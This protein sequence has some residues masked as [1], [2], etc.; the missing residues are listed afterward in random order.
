[1]AR[2]KKR[3][4]GRYQRKVTLS[5][6]KQKFV[7]GKTIAE[8]NAAANALMSQDTAGLE[9]GDHTLVGE[10]TTLEP[11]YRPSRRWRRYD[12]LRIHPVVELSRCGPCAVLPASP[13]AAAHLRNDTLSCRGRL[14]NS[15]KTNGTQQH[16]GHRRYLYSSGT[17]RFAPC[18]R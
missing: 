3:K 15:T 2:L 8:V 5:N 12:P 4:D 10:Y 1:M 14:T 6:G 7:Y 9:V 16:S 17:R 18:R 11:V 13:H